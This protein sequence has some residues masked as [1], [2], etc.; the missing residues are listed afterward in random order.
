MNIEIEKLEE[1]PKREKFP[2]YS[3][4]NDDY[5]GKNFP[6]ARTIRW[7]GSCVGKHIDAVISEFC[8]AK[9]VPIEF[10]NYN[11]LKKYLETD[12]FIDKGEV[13]YY[14]NY[15]LNVNYRK[16]TES[17]RKTF[18]VHPVSRKVEVYNPPTPKSWRKREQEKLDAKVRILGDYHQLY[19]ENGIWYEVKGKPVNFNEFFTLDRKGPKDILLENDNSFTPKTEKYPF[20]KIVLKRQLNKKELKKFGLKNG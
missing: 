12:T 6:Y 3:W 13:Y 11:Q 2:D 8:N 15:A 17:F 19:K 7:L 10:R 14:C 20:V 16:I 9:W 5:W 18:Y 1:L 4:E